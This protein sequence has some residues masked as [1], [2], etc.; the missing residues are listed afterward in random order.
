MTSKNFQN[1]ENM[2]AG[3]TSDPKVEKDLVK[4]PHLINVFP[5]D[6]DAYMDESSD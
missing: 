2:V 1:L 4:F 5:F 3:E 6:P